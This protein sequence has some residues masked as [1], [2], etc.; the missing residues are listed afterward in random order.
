MLACARNLEF[1][2]ATQLRDKLNQIK[3]LMFKT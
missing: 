1:E 3:A 2:R